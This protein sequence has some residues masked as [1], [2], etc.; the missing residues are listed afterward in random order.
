MK[1]RGGHCPGHGRG[2]WNV[3]H[4]SN[5]RGKRSP[6][7]NV[8]AGMHSR[9]RN[10]DDPNYGGRGIQVCARWKSF[11][12]F[13]DDMGP[14]PTAGHSIERVNVNGNYEPSNCT[15]ATRQQQALNRRPRK[16][17]THCVNGHLFTAENEY[18]RSNG[19]RSCKIC[20][21]DAM[22]RLALRGYFKA[23]RNGDKPASAG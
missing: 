17:K 19:K 7:Y 12:R 16:R 13:L 18:V 9:C 15:W 21:A 1:P 10:D 11:E 20:R 2:N 14:R 4:G 6:E 8:W 22:R 5:R 3:Q 23:L